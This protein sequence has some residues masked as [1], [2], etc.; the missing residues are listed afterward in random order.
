MTSTRT[1][2]LTMGLIGTQVNKNSPTIT[3]KDGHTT[4]LPAVYD[5]CMINVCTAVDIPIIKYLAQCPMSTPASQFTTHISHHDQPIDKL[6]DIIGSSLSQ[7]KPVILRG[8]GQQGGEPELTLEFLDEQY[9]ISPNRP[10]WLHSILHSQ[11]YM[12]GMI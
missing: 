10:V 4:I 3:W 9:A 1:K 8:I 5:H 12:H 11:W 7:N 6:Y 2:D